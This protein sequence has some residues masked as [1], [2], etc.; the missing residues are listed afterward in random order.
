[1]SAAA[2]FEWKVGVI[3][4]FDDHE[5]NRS[6]CIAWLIDEG[7]AQTGEVTYKGRGFTVRIITNQ[8]SGKGDAVFALDVTQP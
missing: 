1:M 4:W 3:G 8:V 2:R 5:R 7:F 6:K